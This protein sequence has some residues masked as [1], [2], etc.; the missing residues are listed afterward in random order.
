MFIKTSV[1][2]LPDISANYSQRLALAKILINA[3]HW[4]MINCD[5]DFGCANY[6]IYAFNCF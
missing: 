1:E 5:K 6:E 2:I 3:T 4:T